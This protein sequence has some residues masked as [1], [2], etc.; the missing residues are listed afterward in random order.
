MRSLHQVNELK[1][2]YPNSLLFSLKEPKKK[3]E[4][5]LKFLLALKLY[6]LGKITSGIAARI[7]DVSRRDFILKCNRYNI[8]PLTDNLEDLKEEFDN[9]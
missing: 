7:A 2:Q 3:V 8:S 4:E 5:E 1:I 6:E 9:V